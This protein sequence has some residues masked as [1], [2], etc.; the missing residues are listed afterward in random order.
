MSQPNENDPLKTQ[1]GGDHYKKYKYQ[2]VEFFKD[3][4]G[5]D[6][7]RANI[8]K[9]VARW[10]D[11]GGVEDLKKALHYAMIAQ[12]DQWEKIQMEERFLDQFKRDERLVMNLAMCGDFGQVIAKL[13][14]MIRFYSRTSLEKEDNDGKL[15]E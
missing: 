4:G 10:R 15:S 3:M 5:L 9:Y 1:V 2:P 7:L 11:K 13:K 6:F 8:L 12:E 14:A